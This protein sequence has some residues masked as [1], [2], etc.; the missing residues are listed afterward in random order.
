ML[1]TR[2]AGRTCGMSETPAAGGGSLRVRTAEEVRVALARK[3]MSA[4]Q[5]A[6]RMR[7]SQAYI[8]RR[9]SG[10]TAFDVDD[11]EAIGEILGMEPVDLLPMGATRV[12]Q[13]TRE[14]SPLADRPMSTRPARGPSGNPQNT[15]PSGGPGVRRSRRLGTPAAV[16]GVTRAA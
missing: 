6:K 16:A 13:T 8:W 11:L 7:K 10:E 1:D 5:L 4:T 14:Y 3:R 12:R 2:L 15:H 9:L